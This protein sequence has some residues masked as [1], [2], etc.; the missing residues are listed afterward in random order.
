MRGNKTAW[1]SLLGYARLSAAAAAHTPCLYLL[2]RGKFQLSVESAQVF[3]GDKRQQRSVQGLGSF[4]L[5]RHA[6]Y[7]KPLACRG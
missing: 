7:R 5:L 1:V 3:L 6:F 2:V 4:I